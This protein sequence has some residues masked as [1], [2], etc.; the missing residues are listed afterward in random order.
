MEFWHAYRTTV[1]AVL[2]AC[3]A[4]YRLW[5]VSGVR[6]EG[7]ISVKQKVK[8]TPELEQAKPVSK[9]QCT[10]DA[11]TADSKPS[12]STSPRQSGPRRIKGGLRP[13]PN[14]TEPQSKPVSTNPVQ[15]FVFYSSLT[16]STERIATDF[17][18]ELDQ[19]IQSWPSIEGR[20]FLSVQLMDLTEVELDDYFLTSPKNIDALYL[21]LIPSY[22][23]DTINDTF[24]DHLRETHND[25]RIGTAPLAAGLLG[26]SVFGLGDREN[27]PT[28]ND[29][30]C[31][32]ARE[33]DKWL[34]RLSGKK[35]A[36]PLGMGD[37]KVD[38][39]ERLAEWK[40]GV[41]EVLETAVRTGS[42]GEGVVGS[43]APDESDDDGSASEGDADDEV[44]EEDAEGESKVADLEDL[45]SMVRR[46]GVGSNPERQ[47][48]P[49]VP[50]AVDFTS[51]GQPSIKPAKPQAVPR[52][53]V[54]VNSPTY[55]SLTKQG[56]SIVGSHSAV[57]ICRW[58]KSALRGRGSCYK[59]SFYGIN[60]HQCMET[61]PSLS[62]R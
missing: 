61:T 20:T 6:S 57:K 46:D 29:G 1:I 17:V 40:G 30:F 38:Y 56:Y 50:L 4:A 62:C 33:V 9:A 5:T 36:F 47:S 8:T 54:P 55:A 13:R 12:I 22:N 21:V 14:T 41:L 15:V 39:K 34:A 58:T 23:I 27:W 31:F 32:Q 3:A 42:L 49:T 53:M 25:F 19:D 35:R 52:E 59:F 51:F 11:A 7:A 37:A 18:N 44:Y 28:E 2:L 48:K 43:G 60:S 10:A 45:G 24:L 16:A 26:Y